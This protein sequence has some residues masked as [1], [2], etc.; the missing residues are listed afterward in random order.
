MDKKF[1]L[2]RAFNQQISKN[3][4]TGL[5]GVW[6]LISMNG[7]YSLITGTTII[8]VTVTTAP[9]WAGLVTIIGGANAAMSFSRQ[10]HDGKQDFIMQRGSDVMIVSAYKMKVSDLKYHD[11]RIN[12]TAGKKKQAFIKKR[13]DLQKEIE[14]FKKVSLTK[15]QE[16][17]LYNSASKTKSLKN[18][19]ANVAS[20]QEQSKIEKKL[21]RQARFRQ[22]ILASKNIKPAA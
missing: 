8:G 21:A 20:L 3:I 7:V 10:K 18:K 16:Q 2:R 13:D 1:S 17:S 15:A 9:V 11:Q 22:D 4:Y 14:G 5:G 19:L 6:S 12:E